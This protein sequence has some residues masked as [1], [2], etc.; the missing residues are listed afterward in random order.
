MRLRAARIAACL[1]PVLGGCRM[2]DQ[3]TFERT[4]QAPAAATL[5]R[6]VLPPLPLLVLRMT[7]PQADWRTP[8]DDAVSAA[9]FRKPDVRFEVLTP[10]PV[11]AKKAV[12]DGFLRNGAADAQMVAYALQSDRISA[13]HITL[14]VQG[15]PGTPT[16]EVRL[17][18][19]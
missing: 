10:V 7:D 3:R 13:D 2:I 19:H 16:R 1:V 11:N 9:V 4:P 6:P 15:D 14:G 18:A 8:L 12:Q 5:N 17:Y